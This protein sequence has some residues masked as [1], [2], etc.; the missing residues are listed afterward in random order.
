LRGFKRVIISAMSSKTHLPRFTYA[1]QIEMADLFIV[2][3][4]VNFRTSYWSR[5]SVDVYVKTSEVIACIPECNNM[6][7][8]IRTY[9]GEK[10]EEVNDLIG[11][12]IENLTSF[13]PGNGTLTCTPG[14]SM[15]A[16][17][18]IIVSDAMYNR[19]SRIQ[20]LFGI[21]TARDMHSL[22]FH[23]DE[24]CFACWI[25]VTAMLWHC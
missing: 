5:E 19:H 2:D 24:Q 13:R 17:V 23:G 15:K 6:L 7:V 10:A 21:C 9:K 3:E 22:L 25:Y 4:I 16:I 12:S 8:I 14:Q 20:Q 1:Y 18:P 11:H